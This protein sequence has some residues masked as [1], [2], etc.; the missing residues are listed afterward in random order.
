MQ[1]YKF[2]EGQSPPRLGGV[3]QFVWK[4]YLPNCLAARREAG[5]FVLRL[6]DVKSL[7]EVPYHPQHFRRHG[8]R[9]D[10]IVVFHRLTPT[11]LRKIVRIQLGNLSARLEDHNLQITVTD[12]V[13]DLLATEGCDTA[14]G[15]RPLKRAIQRL[16]VDPLAMKLLSGTLNDGSRVIIDTESDGLGFHVHA[17]QAA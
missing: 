17:P 11:Q 3:F 4:M 16:I 9:I 6:I 15:A 12:A 5:G 8:H 14:Y 13:V 1:L 10:D 2:I 7:N